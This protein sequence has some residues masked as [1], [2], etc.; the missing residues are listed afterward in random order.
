MYPWNWE[1]MIELTGFFIYRPI[2]KSWSCPSSTV[3]VWGF[4]DNTILIILQMYNAAINH[5]SHIGFLLWHCYM[6]GRLMKCSSWIPS[7]WFNDVNIVSMCLVVFTILIVLICIILLSI[8]LNANL[9]SS[10]MTHVPSCNMI[11]RWGWHYSVLFVVMRTYVTYIK[12][13]IT[14]WKCRH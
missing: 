3:S 14:L 7:L 13:P 4:S 6:T 11:W 9:F 8:V 12:L 10:D 2:Y 1:R 5:H